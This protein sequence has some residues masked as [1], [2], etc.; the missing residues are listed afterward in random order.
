MFRI[1]V[2]DDEAYFRKDL[3]KTLKSLF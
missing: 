1:G 3:K 2:C